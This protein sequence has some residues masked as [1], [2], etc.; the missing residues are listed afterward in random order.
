MIIV[1]FVFL[2]T[3]TSFIPLNFQTIGISN[4]F[5]NRS[6]Y[7]GIG[8]E[9]HEIKSKTIKVLSVPEI[10]SNDKIEDL[11]NDLFLNNKEINL[12]GF[13]NGDII[14]KRLARS[15]AIPNGKILN[16]E[17]QQELLAS[18]FACKENQVSPFN[19]PI[20]INF[21]SSDLDKQIS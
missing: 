1:F 6:I 5:E 15:M 8:F 20:L 12:D 21:D 18:L 10:L 17:E 2:S 13:S 9:F 16:I 14:S 4:F 3:P 11:L 19:L 7:E